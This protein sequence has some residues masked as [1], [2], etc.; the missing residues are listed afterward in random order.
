MHGEQRLQAS[1]FITLSHMPAL[2][3][4]RGC[5]ISLR[6]SRVMAVCSFMSGMQGWRESRY[7]SDGDQG[8]RGRVDALGFERAALT[9]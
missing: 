5:C 8:L 7:E 3:L 1:G 6:E 4:S 9:A 2:R